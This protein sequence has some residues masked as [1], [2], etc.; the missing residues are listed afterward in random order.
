MTRLVDPDSKQPQV[1]I[2]AKNEE[3]A[4][5][6]RKF[7]QLLKTDGFEVNDLLL[8]VLERIVRDRSPNGIPGNPQTSIKAYMQPAPQEHKPLEQRI[9]PGCSRRMT[10]YPNDPRILCYEC[11]PR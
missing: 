4:K 8:P 5:L 2:R 7:K 11:E 10:Y 9:C 6:I 3:Q 1:K